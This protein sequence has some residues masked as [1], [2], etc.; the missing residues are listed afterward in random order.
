MYI[1]KEEVVFYSS[2]GFYSAFYGIYNA[3]RFTKMILHVLENKIGILSNTSLLRLTELPID[4]RL[5]LTAG[6]LLRTWFR[7][8]AHVGQLFSR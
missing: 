4:G 7:W 8:L 6:S 1:S 2:M 5:P 3:L